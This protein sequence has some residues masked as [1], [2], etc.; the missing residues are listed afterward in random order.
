M[1]QAGV[2]DGGEARHVGK[3]H[4]APPR[5]IELRN[6]HTICHP[7]GVAVKER[8]GARVPG[9]YLDSGKATGHE[10]HHPRILRAVVA[11][12]GGSMMVGDIQ[13]ADR[14]NIHCDGIGDGAKARRLGR[15]GWKQG[16]IRISGLEIFENRHRLGHHLPVDIQRRHIADGVARAMGIGTVLACQQIHHHLI[17]GKPLEVQCDAHPVTCRGAPV[18]IERDIGHGLLT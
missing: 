8:A 3:V 5:V 4:V 13:V 9:H 7:R 2:L 17:I 1:R 12:K 11:V 18:I 15:I 6:K 16:R 10:M 14:V